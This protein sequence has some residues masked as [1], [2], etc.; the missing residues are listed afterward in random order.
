MAALVPDG[1]KAMKPEIT[2]NTQQPALNYD[3]Y[4]EVRDWRRRNWRLN[5]S[6]HITKQGWAI[7]WQVV[8]P[9]G[10]VKAKLDSDFNLAKRCLNELGLVDLSLL[11]YE[12]SWWVNHYTNGID[13]NSIQHQA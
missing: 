13:L 9:D 4:I 1:G 2:P 5:Y 12:F 11:E 8:Q 10:T 7:N 3:S 6:K